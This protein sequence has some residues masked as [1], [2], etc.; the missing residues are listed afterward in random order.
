MQ[1]YAKTFS[2]VY[3]LLIFADPEIW[4]VILLSLQVT[5]SAVAISAVVGLPLGAWLA[6]GRFRGHRAL[7]VGLNAMM[8]FPPVVIGLLVYMMLSNAGPLGVLGLLYTP[9]AMVIA[10][11][12]LV[13]PIIASLTHQ[14]CRD[15]LA[16]YREQFASL[17]VVGFDRLQTLLFEARHS[18]MTAI[19]AGFG[20]AIAE[21]GAV[22]IVGGNINHLT[23]VMTTTIALETSKGN[24]EIAL[25]LGIVLLVISLLVNILLA[26]VG[27]FGAKF[28]RGHHV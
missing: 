23:R 2:E 10:Q 17:G 11:V 5:I 9:T 26:Y 1:D 15:L 16:E 20:R 28:S 14:T 7:I 25:A 22:M 21:V 12:I 4:S 24:L 19:L 18:L 6:M 3:N 13:I 8:G 27:T